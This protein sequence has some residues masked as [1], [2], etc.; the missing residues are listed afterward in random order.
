MQIRE[1]SGQKSIRVNPCNP[2]TKN[3]NMTT[4]LI[5]KQESHN[6]I[7]ACMEVH[8]ELGCGF[9]EPVYQEALEL[10]FQKQKIPYSREKRL[11]IYYKGTKLKKEYIADFICYNK[12]IVE[13]KA[14]S[15]L[16]TK[17]EAQV[18]NYLKA[19]NQKLGLLINFGAESLQFKRFVY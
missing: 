9:L 2:W 8:N 1:I 7:H 4:K 18:L 6:I 3:K 13:L 11:Y 17:H 14:L 12:I 15:E 5:Y 16:T 10:E 19:T